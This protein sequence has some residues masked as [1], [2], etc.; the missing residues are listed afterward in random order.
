MVCTCRG[1]M[2]QEQVTQLYT[3][4]HWKV[5][6]AV[7]SEIEHFSRFAVWPFLFTVL[8]RRTCHDDNRLHTHINDLITYCFALQMDKD[9]FVC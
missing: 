6:A 9:L 4:S 7:L 3:G 8:H 2:S 1:D 5:E